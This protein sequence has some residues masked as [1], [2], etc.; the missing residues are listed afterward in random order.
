MPQSVADAAAVDGHRLR[1][2][3]IRKTS[4][5][6]SLIKG[7]FGIDR[8]FGH[9]GNIPHGLSPLPNFVRHR[10]RIARWTVGKLIVHALYCNQKSALTCVDAK[11]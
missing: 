8:I 5:G 3:A 6:R 10:F 2:L 9:Q 4:W 11:A 1:G 7:R